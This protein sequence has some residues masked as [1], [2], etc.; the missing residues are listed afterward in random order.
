VRPS[1]TR[2]TEYESWTVGS[3]SCVHLLRTRRR[4]IEDFPVPPSPQT[5]MLMLS[6]SGM[7]IAA[8]FCLSRWWWS[9][10]ARARVY[11]RYEGR[12]VWLSSLLRLREE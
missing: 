4:E 11:V 3:Y 10:C 2:V 5:V 8:I 12:W 7:S 6:G 9:V 1:T